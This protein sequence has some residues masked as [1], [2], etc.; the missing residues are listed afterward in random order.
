MA[1]SFFQAIMETGVKR[2]PKATK[3][4]FKKI[5]EVQKKDSDIKRQSE[6]LL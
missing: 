5:S 6:V 1:A 4:A 2:K 3:M